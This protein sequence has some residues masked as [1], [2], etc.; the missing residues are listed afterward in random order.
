MKERNG[1]GMRIGLIAVLLAALLTAG[2]SLWSFYGSAAYTSAKNSSGTAMT[3]RS[4]MG[5]GQSL[6]R[7]RGFSANRAETGD[8]GYGSRMRGN[9]SSSGSGS[10]N[11]G[12]EP[13]SGNSSDNSSDNSGDNSGGN[14]EGN[15]G[16]SSGSEMGMG[17]SFGGQAGA[18]SGGGVGGRGNGGGAGR[19]FG[20]NSGANSA[21]RTPLLL[22]ALGFAALCGAGAL[23]LRKKG[24]LRVRENDRRLL[25]ATVLGA[26]FLLRVAA[27]P[28]ISGHFDLSLFRSWAVAA[29]QGLENV[30]LK[31]NV[32]Y[33]PFYMYF[34]YLIG[35]AMSG[36]SLSGYSTLLLKLPSIAADV[37]TAW[38]LY[39]LA[40]KRFS[41]GTSLLLAAFYVLNPAVLINST[42]WGQVD[43]FFTLLIVLALAAIAEKKPVWSAVAFA[44]AV[45][46]KPQ[47]IIF[48]PVLFFE[49]VRKRSLKTWLAA[50]AA[51]IG[52]AAL[53]AIPF[54]LKQEPLWLIDLFRST[55]GEY[56]YASVNAYNFFSLIGANYTPSSTTWFLF[57]YHVW[58]LVF[59]AVT[60]L[61]SWAV[62]LRGRSPAFAF[63]AGLIQIAGVFTFSTSMHERYLFPAV[64]LALAAYVAL[65]DKRL[66]AFAAAFSV[67]VYVNTH[68]IFFSGSPGMNGASADFPMLAVS[69]LN[70][71]LCF[72]LAKT[73]WELSG[74]ERREALAAHDSKDEAQESPHANDSA[75]AAASPLTLA[76]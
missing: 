12:G 49:L 72:L 24:M 65:R 8:S 20:G 40:G 70:V 64:A 38:F 16:G 5:G 53:I 4:F 60:T 74:K 9:W 2:Y 52:T 35:K 26:G 48:L 6:G 61:F 62:Y 7:Q 51:G 25:V 28:W 21:E 41:F 19:G 13:G 47:G 18:M 15:S 27:A 50:A 43:S 22:Y 11:S 32:D 42:V 30:Y 58:G 14:S 56:P 45:M 36:L 44:A 1:N 46:M 33:P 66:L 63:L 76:D 37:L 69:L 54:S 23:V 73:A 59:I 75:P 57:S 55:V 67:S 31:S 39:R 3:G 68:I 34:L 29:A 10:G 71:V 17:Y